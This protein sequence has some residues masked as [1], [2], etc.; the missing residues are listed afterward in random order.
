V[1]KRVLA[2]TVLVLL[3]A[4]APVARAADEST[5]ALSEATVWQKQTLDKLQKQSHYMQ[6]VMHRS[7]T[8][9]DPSAKGWLHSAATPR[10]RDHI[11]IALWKRVYTRTSANYRNPPF[12]PALTCIH[13]GE[14]A[15]NDMRNPSYDG[16]LQLSF[17]FQQRYGGY[18]LR[19]K[20]RAYNWT[21]LEQIWTAVYAIRGPDHR[22]FYPWP[23]TARAC[24]LI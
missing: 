4:A 16:G 23:T 8:S 24:N 3:S 13:R 7:L 2:T 20:G 18:L 9:I 10:E 12:L 17:T 11:L 1:P 5:R 22:G 6:R 14:G 19:V 15:W 21:P